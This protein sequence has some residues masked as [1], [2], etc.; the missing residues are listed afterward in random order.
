VDSWEFD[1]DLD[2]NSGDKLD[3]IVSRLDRDQAVTVAL[4]IHQEGWNGQTGQAS[5][6]QEQATFCEE[7]PDDSHCG[8]HAILLVGYDLD[9]KAFRFK[10][11]WGDDW[12]Q[13]GYGTLE[14][15]YVDSYSRTNSIRTAVLSGLDDDLENAPVGTDTVANVTYRVVGNH[16]EDGQAG[17]QLELMYEHDAPVG[18]F[19]YAS[20]FLMRQGA[21][22]YGA[23]SYTDAE[24]KLQYVAARH[25][26][27]AIS[28]DDLIHTEDNPL[29]FF[30]PHSVM[31]QAGVSEDDVLALRPSIY[32]M[33]DTE[34][35]T[36]LFREMTPFE[37]QPQPD[38]CNGETW[39]GRCEDGA[40]IWCEEQ[41]VHTQDC[42]EQGLEC[43][44]DPEKEY[45]A[46]RRP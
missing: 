14:F 10:N 7:N 44:W 33:T 29:T 43:V 19:Y 28:A 23:V 40:V 1:L 9:Q 35:Y 5:Y 6:S 22:G 39:E 24:D 37:Y 32:R 11:S 2:T 8:G 18:T 27:V 26:G 34:S 42:A 20:V 30:I 41:Q 12:G 3:W 15:D 46:C 38:P 16:L 31:E 25:Y 17:V 21:G 4:P 45:Y 13:S 36:V